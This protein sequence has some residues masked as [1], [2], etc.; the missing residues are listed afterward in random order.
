VAEVRFGTKTGSNDFFILEDLTNKAASAQLQVAIN[1]LNRLSTKKELYS[2]GLRLVKNGLDELWLIEAKFLQPMLTSPKDVKTYEARP[3]ELRYCVLLVD[4]KLSEIKKDAPYL[5]RYIRHAEKQHISDRPSLASRQKWYDIGV[6]ERPNLSFSY[7]INDFGKTIHCHAYT[8]DNFHNIFI[9]KG[10]PR[11]LFLLLNSTIAWLIQQ[12]T[13]RTNFGEGVGKI[14]AYELANFPILDIDLEKLKI[15]LGE[16]LNYTKEFGTL[17]SL[18]TVNPQRIALDSAILE[19]IGYTKAKERNEVLLALYRATSGMI[20]ARLS[21]AQSLS[22]VKTQRNKVALSVY[23]DQLKAELLAAGTQVKKT[24]TFARQLQR[25][26]QGI[27]SD[28]KLQKKIFDTF[29][30][31]R[32]NEAFNEK[33]IVTSAQGKMF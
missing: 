12:L 21:K 11:T 6:G 19:A 8:N 5:F 17:E 1:N 3:A 4:E 24:I 29:W 26:I 30:K 18:D 14:Q 16:T 22:G 10:K 7:M 13:I 23:V 9:R 25:H 15:S 31:A 27:T 32:F 2:N 20:A 33:A 28:S